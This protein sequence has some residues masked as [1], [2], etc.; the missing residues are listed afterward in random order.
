AR[1][2]GAVLVVDE[3]GSHQAPSVAELLAAHGCAVEIATP[4][5]VVGGELEP[6]GDLE[7]FNMRA[8]ARQIVQSTDLV[9]TALEPGGVRL[10]HH[11]TGTVEQRAVDWVVLAVAPVSEDGLYK[12][13][14]SEA[15]GL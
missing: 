3:L 8:A 15:P 9:V 2:E 12:D 13:L 7:G 5:M 1:P 6:T 4:A 10:L 11:P 14:R